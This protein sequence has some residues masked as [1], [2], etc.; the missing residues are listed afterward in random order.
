MR[1]IQG[2]KVAKSSVPG[3]RLGLFAARDFKTGEKL[4]KYSGDWVIN[5]DAEDVNIMTGNYMLGVTKDSNIDAARM[6]TA[7]GRWVNDPRGTGKPPNCVFALQRMGDNSS[8]WLRASKAIK[9]GDELFVSYGANY[10]K[11]KPPAAVPPPVAA[12]ADPVGDRNARAAR[13][14]PRPAA[15]LPPAGA[16]QPAALAAPARPQLVMEPRIRSAAETRAERRLE[17]RQ[18]YLRRA[19][20]ERLAREAA[21]RRVREESTDESEDEPDVLLEQKEEGL[22][23]RLEDA[24]LLQRFSATAAAG[25]DSP[26][27]ATWQALRDECFAEDQQLLRDAIP[28]VAIP[29]ELGCAGV[30]DVPFRII[31]KGVTIPRL[32]ELHTVLYRVVAAAPSYSA[33]L[34]AATEAVVAAGNRD[35][36]ELGLSKLY[37]TEKF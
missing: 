3:A 9:K 17:N 34:A 22:R 2:V 1:T 35:P 20:D 25:A 18:I 15:A 8:C 24:E 32:P 21:Q 11:G 4:V 30:D 14:D 6:N 19:R 5:G 31:I 7:A 29:L 33:A 26:N 27:D 37:G 12:A 16:P 28:G 23:Q 36:W 13:R 10:W